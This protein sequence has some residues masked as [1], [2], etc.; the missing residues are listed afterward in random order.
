MSRFFCSGT[1]LAGMERE[2]MAQ[3]G[4]GARRVKSEEDASIRRGYSKNQ[5][6]EMGFP[7]GDY[8]FPVG[9]GVFVGELVMKKWGKQNSLICYFD[10]ED[11]SAYKLCVWFN[12]NEAHSYR[13]RQSNLDI[14]RV[15]IGTILRV[16][17]A[18][19]ASGKT[20]WLN[21]EYVEV[22]ENASDTE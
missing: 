21:A 19:T 1:S 5:V 14:S 10:T 3:P 16:T 18:E 13:P 12:P 7:I 22:R 9:S 20:S 11:G 15:E 17:F 6:R 4:F 8:K 2:M